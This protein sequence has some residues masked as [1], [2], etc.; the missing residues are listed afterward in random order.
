[1]R[2]TDS[3]SRPL[4]V[5]EWLSSPISEPFRHLWRG[6][7]SV[8]V[9]PAGAGTALLDAWSA[10]FAPDVR[11]VDPLRDITS[12]L[13]ILRR[14]LVWVL[15][16]GSLLV[17]ALVLAVFKR[18]A[19]AALAPTAL[20]AA[21]GLATLGWTGMP[22][23][24]FSLLALALILGMGIDYGIFIQ[25]NRKNRA[26]A[27]MA[28]NVGAASTILAFG[29]LAFSSTPALKGFGLVLATGLGVAWLTAPCFAPVEKEGGFDEA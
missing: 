1:M 20:G 7:S 16:A 10:P 12:T 19:G 13:G 25:E 2:E 29:M 5:A 14:H 4:T 21:V 17:A 15:A 27:L 28:I 18:H 11:L 3:L 22:L 26:S 24:L 6:S 9:V 8:A 23:N